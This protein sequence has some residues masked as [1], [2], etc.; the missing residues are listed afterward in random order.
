MGRYSVALHTSSI[1]RRRQ[2]LKWKVFA[3]SGDFAYNN[4]SALFC[5]SPGGVANVI[6]RIDDP[7]RPAAVPERRR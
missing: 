5:R 1:D 4:V 3:I 6:H 2:R 7:L